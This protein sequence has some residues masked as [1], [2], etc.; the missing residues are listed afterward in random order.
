MSG[1]LTACDR[2]Q[3][4][5]ERMHAVLREV[6]EWLDMKPGCLSLEQI[7]RRVAGVLAEVEKEV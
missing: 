7:E 5:H 2:T 1:A 3:A 6:L 4:E